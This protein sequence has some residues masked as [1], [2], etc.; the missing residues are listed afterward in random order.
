MIYNDVLTHLSIY[1]VTRDVAA[2]NSAIAALETERD[3]PT[4]SDTQVTLTM[5]CA[6]IEQGIHNDGSLKVRLLAEGQTVSGAVEE[7]KFFRVLGSD[8]P[9][10]TCMILK[11]TFVSDNVVVFVPIAPL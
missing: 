7:G 3:N 6:E 2:L 8:Q 11:A 10:D 4:L 9:E 5:T 1:L